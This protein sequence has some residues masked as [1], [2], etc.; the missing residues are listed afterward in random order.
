[1][2]SIRVDAWKDRGQTGSLI[3][4]E[5]FHFP[6][7]LP[8]ILSRDVGSRNNLTLKLRVIFLTSIQIQVTQLNNTSS[9]VKLD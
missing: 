4:R 8:Q 7:L 2:E 6:P 9:R 3:V 5:K 1:M